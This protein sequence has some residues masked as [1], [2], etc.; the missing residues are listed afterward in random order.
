MQI[1]VFFF[2]FCFLKAFWLPFRLQD[3]MLDYLIYLNDNGALGYTY[4]ALRLT[5]ILVPIAHPLY[6]T[7]QAG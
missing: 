3:K 5:H 2:I 6:N 4:H 7:Y 1:G